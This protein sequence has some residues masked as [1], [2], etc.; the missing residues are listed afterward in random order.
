MS[1]RLCDTLHH[2][3][4][5]LV[6]DQQDFADELPLL[7]FKSLLTVLETNITCRYLILILNWR[8]RSRHASFYDFIIVKYFKLH[9]KS[10]MNTTD[11]LNILQLLT[12]VMPPLVS[13][14]EASEVSITLRHCVFGELCI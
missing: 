2:C 3:Y 1:T 7:F 14:V 4:L 12:R 11:A 8:K 10:V 9:H 5:T 13:L 6:W